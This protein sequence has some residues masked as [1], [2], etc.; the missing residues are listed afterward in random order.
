MEEGEE[1]R[2]AGQAGKLKPKM[3]AQLWLCR[4]DGCKD[5]GE[6]GGVRP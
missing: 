6:E 4:G 1:E 2:A 5:S 3:N